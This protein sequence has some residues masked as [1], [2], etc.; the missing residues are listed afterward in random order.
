MLKTYRA[1]SMAAALTEVKKDLGADAVIVN[2]RT[3]RA[4]GV[5]GIGARN[6]IEI[7][8]S[9]GPPRAANAASQPRRPESARERLTSQASGRAAPQPSTAP[10]PTADRLAEPR[11]ARRVAADGGFT[12]IKPRELH[13]AIAA[14]RPRPESVSASGG[15]VAGV[16][17]ETDGA[18]ESAVAVLEPPALEAAFPEASP[19]QAPARPARVEAPLAT[20]ARLSPVSDAA[21]AAIDEELASIKRMVVQVLQTSRQTAMRVADPSRGMLST[22]NIAGASTEPLM[23]MSIRLLDAQLAPDLA[24]VLLGKVRDELS[25]GE[26]AD[27]VVVREATLRH[28]ARAIPIAPDSTLRRSDSGRPFTLALVGPT[29]V[30]KTTTI[31]K[32]AA[33]LKLR[34]AKKV[35]LVTSDTYRIAAVEQL[36]TYANIIGLPLKIAHS[37]EDMAAA[38]EAHADCDV[39]LVDTAGRSQHDADRLDELRRQRDAA[40]PHQTHLVLAANACESVLLRAAERF[41]ALQPDRLLITKLDE[42]VAFGPVVNVATRIGLGLSFVTTGQEVPDHIER[43]RAERLARMVLDGGV[44]R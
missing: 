44:G 20:T 32:L 38:C 42:A 15:G 6:V 43:A 4:G 23:A 33:A 14:A 35:G 28:L 13:E 19:T 34:H 22:T 27:E 21:R 26:L 2:T 31:A 39:I 12:P 36:R 30:G 18:S 40:Q 8:A 10:R 7:T 11:Q 5:L 25:P 16:P 37:P 29:G 1:L 41:R 3:L 9:P 24:D 17:H